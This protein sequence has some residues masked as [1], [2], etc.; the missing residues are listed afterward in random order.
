[1]IIWYTS[2][3]NIK[4]LP[5]IFSS[6]TYYYYFFIKDIYKAQVLN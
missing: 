6:F 1:M 4:D 2:P 5:K 3:A